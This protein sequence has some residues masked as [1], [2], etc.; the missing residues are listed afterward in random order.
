MTGRELIVYILE[1][2]LENE[3][4]FKDGEILGFMSAGKAAEAF[5]VGLATIHVW[6]ELGMIRH[7]VIGDT[8]YIPIDTESPIGRTLI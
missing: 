8:I 4:I 6:A 5:N 2:G 7:I 3:P 1:N